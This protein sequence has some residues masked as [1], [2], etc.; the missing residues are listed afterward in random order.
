MISDLSMQFEMAKYTQMT[1]QANH[2]S[3]DEKHALNEAIYTYYEAKSSLKY[4]D[5]WQF[6]FSMTEEQQAR[7]DGIM[8]NVEYDYKVRQI[9]Y[10][11]YHQAFC[12]LNSKG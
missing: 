11:M 8:L 9:L 5:N 1:N 2:L 4:S 6:V 3:D 12:F 7:L 10:H